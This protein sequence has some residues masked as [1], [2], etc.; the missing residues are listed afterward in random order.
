MK[1]KLGIYAGAF[2]PIHYGHLEVA[3]IAVKE[4]GLDKMYF[5]VEEN[6]WGSKNPVDINHRKKMVNIALRD[7]DNTELLEIK[8]SQFTI[9]ETLPLI[10]NTFNDSELYFIFGADIFMKM[11]PES[12]PELDKLLKHYIVVFER[13][14][15]SEVDITNHAKELGI[16]TAIMPSTHP[17]HSST[18]VRLSP[19]KKTIWV[20]SKVAHYIDEAGIYK[21]TN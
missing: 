2:D 5:M 9:S 6:P 17:N 19:H 21:T 20:P 7:Y 4:L 11:S 1:K 14:S 18:D 13:G 16:V 12:W 15:I 3:N 8:T 10:E